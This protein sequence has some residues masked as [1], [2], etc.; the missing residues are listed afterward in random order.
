MRT[1]FTASRAARYAP[2]HARP[3]TPAVALFLGAMNLVPGTFEG[4]S[5]RTSLGLLE[6]AMGEGGAA[7]RSGR[8]CLSTTA[9]S[10]SANS[11]SGCERA[12]V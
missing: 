8:P 9:L 4:P 11:S 6:V 10:P 1:F 2:R 3:A 5:V 12:W 7:P